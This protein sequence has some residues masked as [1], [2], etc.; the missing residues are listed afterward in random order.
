MNLTALSSASTQERANILL[1]QTSPV[2]SDLVDQETDRVRRFTA[3]AVN[4]SID[5]ETDRRIT[6]YAAMSE[7]QIR[8]RIHA[9]DQEWDI[10]R[11]LALNAATLGLSGVALSW[12]G[13]RRWLALP[14]VALVF[15]FQHAVQGWCLPLP[16]L[17]RL[18]IRT[19]GEIDREKYAL[20]SLLETG[21][22]S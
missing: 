7:P 3:R 13:D 4:R 22:G 15:L 8:Q 6:R 1:G 19:R 12:D 11:V 21:A 17:R 9:L 10:E 18:G 16:V 14:A 20:L 5:Q 2:A